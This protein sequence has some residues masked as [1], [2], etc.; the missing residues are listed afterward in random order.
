VSYFLEDYISAKR[1]LTYWKELLQEWVFLVHRIY[2]ISGKRTAVYAEKER[3]NT[4][5]IAAAATRNGWVALE[6]CRTD[7]V[8]RY[9][10]TV[11][12]SGRCDLVLWRD[13]RHHEIEA[14]LIR[15]A[16]KN[17][18]FDRVDLTIERAIQDASRSTQSG[19]KSEKKIAL[20]YIVPVIDPVRY[21]EV[22]YDEITEWLSSLVSHIKINHNPTLLSYAFPGPVTLEGSDQLGLGVILYG[23]CVSR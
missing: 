16:M 15:V 22:S 6:E 18:T 20:A 11:T 8:D 3:A 9:A 7:K 17:K 21:D 10:K 2:R 23:S 12:Y 14:K 13:R 1:P 5:L 4:G 19:Y